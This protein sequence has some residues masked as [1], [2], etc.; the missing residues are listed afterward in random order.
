MRSSLFSHIHQREK[1]R[2]SERAKKR[3]RDELD[4]HEQFCSIKRESSLLM[5]ESFLLIILQD[6]DGYQRCIE[7]NEA[8]PPP[9][10]VDTRRWV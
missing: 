3:K 4:G 8:T 9:A 10:A 6:D 2:A 1:H 5:L 7:I